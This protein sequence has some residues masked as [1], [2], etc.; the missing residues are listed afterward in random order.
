MKSLKV[1]VGLIITLVLFSLIGIT[2]PQKALLGK[3]AYLDWKQAQPT[4]VTLLEALKL[5]DFY[6]S[7][8]MMALWVVFF[9]N[10]ILV[11]ADRV[12]G[13]WRLCREVWLPR[14][15]GFVRSYRCTE[16]LAKVSLDTVAQALERRGYRVTRDGA[17]LAGVRNRYAPLA[18]LL[19]HLSF[20]LL[21]GGGVLTVYT[22]FRAEADVAVGE[23]FNGAYTKIMARPKFGGI[24]NSTFTVVAVKPTYYNR[25]VPVDLVVDLD[26]RQGSKRISI[27]RPYYDGALSFLIKNIDVAPLFVVQN[28]A[29]REVDSAFVKLKNLNGEEDS[30]LLQGY[31]FRTRF[32]TDIVAE[33]QQ[34]AA[35]SAN[36]PQ[37]LKQ[38][39][40]ASSPNQPK[41]IIN[42]AITI[43][44]EK[45]GKKL[46]TVTLRLHESLPLDNG[47][48]LV[49]QDYTYW[50]NF[51][52]GQERGLM[53]VYAA[54]ML[55]LIALVIRFSFYRR[56]IRAFAEDGTLCVGGRSE[57]F[58]VMFGKEFS[59][60]IE[61]M[62]NGR[63]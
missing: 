33:Q 54:F 53:V 59:T 14:D 15:S 26:T 44:M 23:V 42:P 17:A 9:C 13:I 10:L 8:L 37:V 39:P 46:Q 24:P 2:L 48:R 43:T 4:L 21:L 55:M 7:P 11:M 57:Y 52:V 61:V 63:T 6:S 1:T 56:D 16:D 30:F 25:T 36:L 31:T 34:I 60:L 40:N 22:K 45:E 41:E 28:A 12:P 18:T 35:T 32:H 29:G 27:N 58:P 20:L 51:Y 50:V 3:E 49:W 5:T 62:R 47:L 19:F 38:Q